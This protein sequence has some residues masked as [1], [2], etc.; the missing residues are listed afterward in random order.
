MDNRTI[1]L[2]FFKKSFSYINHQ[3]LFSCFLQDKKTCNNWNYSFECNSSFFY[4]SLLFSH[5][6]F[7]LF[8]EFLSSEESFDFLIFFDLLEVL[9]FEFLSYFFAV[10]EIFWKKNFVGH[11]MFRQWLLYQIVTQIEV[12]QKQILQLCNFL[13]NLRFYKI[14]LVYLT[15]M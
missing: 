13:I 3:T 7:V 5:I 1:L 9:I 12:I 6:Y 8:Q 4:I 14:I 11:C 15:N 10:F 2:H